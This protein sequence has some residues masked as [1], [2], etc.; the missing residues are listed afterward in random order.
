MRSAPALAN[1]CASASTGCD[2][3]VHVDRHRRAVGAHRVLAQRLADHRA[4]RQVRHVVV[5]HHVEVD[6]VGAGGDDVAHLVAEAGEVGRQDAGGDAIGA[7]MAA[8]DSSERAADRPCARR[9]PRIARWPVPSSRAS[10]ARAPPAR[11][12]ATATAGQY[13]FAYTVT[14]RNSGDVTAQLIARHWIITDANGHVEEVRGLGGRRPPAA[15]EARRELRVH[16]LDAASRRRSGTMRGTYFCM[17]ED[18]HPFE[19]P[20]AEFGLTLASSLH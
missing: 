17:T 10:V 15:A 7:C 19:A 6:P 18:A 1:A 2:H 20:I 16:E 9:L 11:A 13:A 3:Q 8:S 14:I 5:V 4:E 12:V